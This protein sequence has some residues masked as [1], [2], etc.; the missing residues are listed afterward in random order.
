VHLVRFCTCLRSLNNT[1]TSTALPTD[2][3]VHTA[4]RY[5]N[6]HPGGEAA[7][8]HEVHW[9]DTQYDWS[10]RSSYCFSSRILINQPPG[11]RNLQRRHQSQARNLM[12]A[13]QKRAL[14]LKF[15]MASPLS[16]LSCE[17]CCCE[18][19]CDVYVLYVFFVAID[20]SVSHYFEPFCKVVFVFVCKVVFVLLCD[21]SFKFCSHQ[22]SYWRG[23]FEEIC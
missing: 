10:T 13:S 7:G 5:S 17:E 14:L 23:N 6:F 1:S 15:K 3:T 16:F 18:L 9:S 8:L 21:H 11:Y 12:T 2:Y 20:G 4:T 22:I 19:H